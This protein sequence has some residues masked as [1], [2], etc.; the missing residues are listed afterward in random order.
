MSMIP[1]PEALRTRV[2]MLEREKRVM[3]DALERV[4]LCLG[5]RGSDDTRISEAYYAAVQRVGTYEDV[6]R[7]KVD[8]HGSGTGPRDP[9][10]D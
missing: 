4:V 6:V 10:D 9:S 7:R 5:Q 1:E 3:A 8:P 2:L